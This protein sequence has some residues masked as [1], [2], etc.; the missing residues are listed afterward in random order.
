MRGQD[1]I[2][3]GEDSVADVLFDGERMEVLNG[4]RIRTSNTH[5]TGCTT[6]SAI[7]GCMARGMAVPA[8]VRAA[9][10]YLTQALERSAHLSIGSGPQRPFNH[11]CVAKLINL[12]PI[13]VKDGG[14]KICLDA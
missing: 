14:C 2:Y 8:A 1:F 5:G 12:H 10:G 7:A 11:G 3:T 4:P 6:A 13:L 9:R